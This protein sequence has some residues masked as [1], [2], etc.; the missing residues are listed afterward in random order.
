MVKPRQSL[1]IAF[2]ILVICSCHSPIQAPPTILAVIDQAGSNRSALE[3][4][5]RHYSKEPGD[6]LQLKATYFLLEE[7]D[8]LATLDTTSIAQNDIYFK[9]I[10]LLWDRV[11]RK[12][13]GYEIYPLI[14]SINN[15]EDLAPGRSQARYV[16]DLS[17]L[18]ADFLINNIDLSF[19]VWNK[20]PY[21]QHVSF[22]V[23]CNYILPYRSAE[24]YGQH[25]K[26]Y[27]RKRYT[28]V[29]SRVK[30]KNDQYEVADSLLAETYSSYREDFQTMKKY[31]YL[32]PI[33]YSNLLLGRIGE[34]HDMNSLRVD[35]LRSF[36]IPAV[37]DG[38]PGW[39]NTG[40]KHFWY[41]IIDPDKHDSL[42]VNQQIPTDRNRI[43]MYY[44]NY[45][46]KVEKDELPPN[47]DLYYCKY[48][49]K[50]YR[51]C[52]AKQP[53]SLAAVNAGR[54]PL[55]EYFRSNR[56]LDV[57]KEY[58][59]NANIEV[60][61]KFD[62]SKKHPFVYLCTFDNTGWNIVD[63]GQ[64]NH[65]KTTFNHV[66]LN[67]VYLPA[68]FENNEIIPAGDAFLLNSEGTIKY[69]L[70]DTIVKEK[71]T[72]IQKWPYHPNMVHFAR[73]AQGARFQLANN[74][75]F[76]DSITIH[77]INKLSF[78]GTEFKTNQPNKYR[79]LIFQFAGL[80]QAQMAELEY[81]GLNKEGKEV[82]LK[83]TISGNKGAGA[84]KNHHL[85]DDEMLTYFV[86]TKFDKSFIAVDLGANNATQI[87]RVR[88]MPRNDDNVISA[89]KK[90]TLFYW[91][92]GWQSLGEKTPVT[93]KALIFDNVPRNALLL[94]K[95]DNGGQE[96]R[97]FTYEKG[98][99][100]F[101]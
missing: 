19:A 5:I 62:T 21:A 51:E 45:D 93:D 39:G 74:P 23:F 42:R 47:V 57:T 30:N 72:Y 29:L 24:T 53:G 17:Y 70:P 11:K 68:W 77:T 9:S 16:E 85:F 26:A 46:I 94:L 25:M 78:Y 49:T 82:K 44:G 84:T 75:D 3:E 10:G 99:Q 58:V 65:Q 27:F 67:I 34:C 63:W 76:S 32:L 73:S 31:P 92:N 80:P 61:L 48:I 89:S 69:L 52:F 88:Y 86:G 13:E 56:L 50:V 43:G 100:Y 41:T 59:R 90:Y 71:Q 20:N 64:V 101:W 54:Y 96:N 22:P 98:K 36:G 4:V 7:L 6:S 83:G 1:S 18:S 40:A 81:W 97:I 60:A 38:I 87:T 95:D 12:P 66:G 8:G 2:S 15:D 37:I 28:N 79:Y 33:K 91:N 14:D 35:I 55:P